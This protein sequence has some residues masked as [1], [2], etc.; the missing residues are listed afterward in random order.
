MH[1][2]EYQLERLSVGRFVDFKG[3]GD[4]ITSIRQISSTWRVASILLKSP[5]RR[6][7]EAKHK[8]IN[9]FKD[10]NE[11]KLLSDEIKSTRGCIGRY[12]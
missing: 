4:N 10:I 1:R 5:N 8:E 2:K 11:R 9:S 6:K 12:M 7:Y 3:I